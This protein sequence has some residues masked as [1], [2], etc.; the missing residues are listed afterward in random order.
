MT[1]SNV[2][3]IP[4]ASCKTSA[5][6]LGLISVASTRFPFIKMELLAITFEACEIFGLANHACFERN[7]SVPRQVA[8]H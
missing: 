6:N 7:Q 5:K 2:A 3:S 4:S 8:R 1:S